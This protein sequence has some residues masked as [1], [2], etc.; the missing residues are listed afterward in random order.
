MGESFSASFVILSTRDDLDARGAEDIVN[1]FSSSR[2]AASS[3]QLKVDSMS[4]CIS[5]GVDSLSALKLLFPPED[6][7]GELR[8]RRSAMRPF[9]GEPP[10]CST[11]IRFNAILPQRGFEVERLRLTI[12]IPTHG[13]QQQHTRQASRRNNHHGT[14]PV[15][16]VRLSTPSGGRSVSTTTV[17]GGLGLTRTGDAHALV[18]C[19]AVL[20]P[21]P[22]VRYK[23]ASERSTPIATQYTSMASCR[24][25]TE[26]RT[27]NRD[28]RIAKSGDAGNEFAGDDGMGGAGGNDGDIDGGCV[29][30]HGK[31]G[32]ESG[33][34]GS[35]GG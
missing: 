32:G 19:V 18:G 20:V 29:G 34:S 9:E 6:F 25:S 28:G 17:G 1:T 33:G 12:A 14:E 3:S 16:A 4:S 13:R 21:F 5:D 35:E 22:H 23:T 26:T 30:L 31:A 8:G 11:R 7:E 15:L 10:S 2:D 27:L 24:S